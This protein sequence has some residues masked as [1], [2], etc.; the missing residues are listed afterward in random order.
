MR[1]EYAYKTYHNDA[2]ERLVLLKYLAN[3]FEYVIV[4]N[5]PNACPLFQFHRGDCVFIT[6]LK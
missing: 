4:E 2:I 1:K 3:S 6:T 5:L